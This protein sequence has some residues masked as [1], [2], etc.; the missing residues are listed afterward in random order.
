MN[1]GHCRVY[2]PQMRMIATFASRRASRSTTAFTNAVVPML[3][4]DTSEAET[5]AVDSSS[6]IAASIPSETLGVVGALKCA[7]TPRDGAEI[8]ETSMRTPSVFVPFGGHE[9]GTPYSAVQ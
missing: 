2:G 7:R 6:R 8:C 4:Q 5:F 9:P 3:T 1:E